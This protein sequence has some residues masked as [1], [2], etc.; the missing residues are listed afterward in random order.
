MTFKRMGVRL[1]AVAVI[2][3]VSVLWGAV[4]LAKPVRE[5]PFYGSG[6]RGLGIGGPRAGLKDA[7]EVLG[8]TV[9]EILTAKSKG[10]TLAQVAAEEGITPEVLVEKILALRKAKLDALVQEGKITQE[11]ANLALEAMKKNIEAMINESCQGNCAGNPGWRRPGR[12]GGN[13]VGAPN[14]AGR[15]GAGRPAHAGTNCPW[16]AAQ[17]Q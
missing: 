9:D 11:Q 8:M 10:K 7:A 2:L 3:A 17:G 15:A 16:G 5:R 4:V 6:T 13:C 12:Q 14:G 1:A